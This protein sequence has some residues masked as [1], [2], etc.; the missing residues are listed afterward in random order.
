MDKILPQ[1][2]VTQIPSRFIPYPDGTRIFVKPYCAGE[3]INI[4]LVGRNNLKFMEEILSGVKVDGLAKNMLTPQDILFLGVYRNLVSSKH[5]KIDIKSICPY[6][7]NEN[8]DVRT[9][10]AI[11]FNDIDKFDKDCYPIEVEFDDY[12]MHFGFVTYKDFELCV[13]KFRGHKLYQLALQVI[14]YTDKKTKETVTKPEYSTKSNKPTATAAI[15]KYVNDV[16]TILYGFVD[17]D[18]ETLEEVVSIL[19]NYGIKQIE[20]TCKDESC[21]HTYSFDIEDEGVLVMPFRES[22][23]SIRTRIKLSKN[24]LD[25]SD[26][27]QT[28]EPSGTMSTDG[29]NE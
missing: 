10:A 23:E 28:D 22:K 7:L 13:N 3:A 24:D 8:H 11:S 25:K 17:E 15:E 2:E 20:T 26:S 1:Y 6:C 4:E 21:K 18:K 16:K 19:E 29:H 27:I 9:L 14:D 12:I 5:D